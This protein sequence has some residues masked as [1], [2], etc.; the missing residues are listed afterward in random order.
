MGRRYDFP[1]LKRRLSKTLTP[2]FYPVPGACSED[3]EFLGEAEAVA[4]ERA[5]AFVDAWALLARLPFKVGD[6]PGAGGGWVGPALKRSLAST[7]W[8]GGNPPVPLSL[9]FFEPFFG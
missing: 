6:T 9:N 5:D 8:G 1:P 2:R 4:I 3:A 7:A